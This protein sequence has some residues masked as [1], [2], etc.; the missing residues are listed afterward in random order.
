MSSTASL[1]NFPQSIVRINSFQLV[2]SRSHGTMINALCDGW[3]CSSVGS[4]SN[5][6]AAN[7]GR[8]DSPVRQRISLPE[9]TFSADSPMMSV[10]PRIQLHILTSV[11][12]VKDP[13]V[14]VRVRWIMET[15][16]HP[17][18]T[19]DWTLQLCHNWFSLR[20]AT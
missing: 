3:G 5:R 8:F 15:L 12:H 4:A 13:V 11:A 2:I 7:V 20:K 19:I 10:H 9:S 1:G 17:A 18:C 14:N 6:H 16:K